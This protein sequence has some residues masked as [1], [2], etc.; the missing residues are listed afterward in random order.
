MHQ[1]FQ[2]LIQSNI[3]RTKS[4]FFM[5]FFC[6]AFGANAQ[7]HEVGIWGGI[8]H[9]SGDL[10]PNDKIFFYEPNVSVG[11]HYQYHFLDRLAIRGMFSYSQLSGSDSHFE[12][13]EPHR[14]RNLHFKTPLLELAVLL[15]VDILP[16]D[17]TIKKRSFTPFVSLG[18]AGFYFN[19]QAK[20]NGKWIDL[21]PLGTEGQGI[22]Q[23]PDR[24][25]YSRFE[26]AIP[27]GLGIKFAISSHIYCSIEAAAR[28][29]FTDY[30]DDVG[31]TY[32]P[33]D[34]LS[35]ENGKMAADLSNR[36]YDIEGKQIELAGEK[37][38]GKGADWYFMFGATVNYRLG[39][40][41]PTEKKRKWKLQ[42]WL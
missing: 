35:K 11:V 32:I 13:N 14:K 21:Q 28:K 40:S 39:S 42:K 19:P 9:Y 23:Y 33:L 7:Y 3:A 16:F 31:N 8:A 26:M 34:I 41:S 36:T 37:R 10:T 17:P 22:E 5:L 38:G 29:T 24:Q 20:I 27:I 6:I 30:I 2:T 15:V 4:L 25:K 18:I 12:K 1:N